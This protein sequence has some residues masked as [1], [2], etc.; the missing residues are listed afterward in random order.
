MQPININKK[1]LQC[2]LNTNFS[3]YKKGFSKT[4]RSMWLVWLAWAAR[5]ASFDLVDYIKYIFI[6]TGLICNIKK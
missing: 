1:K 5:L 3:H 2:I 4:Y 6:E